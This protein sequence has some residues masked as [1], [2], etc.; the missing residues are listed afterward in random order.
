MC[1]M[2]VMCVLCMLC[3]G[4]VY[5]FD[6]VLLLTGGTVS[7]T[8]NLKTP[9]VPLKKVI[10]KSPGWQSVACFALS[11]LLFEFEELNSIIII[12]SPSNRITLQ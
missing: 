9:N 4:N 12:V 11:R 5:D 3:N 10:L 7:N 2:C 1:V 8:G 6:P